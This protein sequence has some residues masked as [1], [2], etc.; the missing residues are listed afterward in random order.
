[1]PFLALPFFE[2]GFDLL[3]LSSISSIFSRSANP[4]CESSLSDFDF[5]HPM[6]SLPLVLSL[7]F[8]ELDD[9]LPGI[10]RI[11]TASI[12]VPSLEGGG[13]RAPSPQKDKRSFFLALRDFFVVL[14]YL[15]PVLGAVISFVALVGVTVILLLFRT[16]SLLLSGLS[17]PKCVCGSFGPAPLPMQPVSSLIIP[18][19]VIVLSYWASEK[20]R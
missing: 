10:L 2:L 3:G 15:S 11:L 12:G 1:L 20:S 7:F 13:I 9:P 6:A 18:S 19:L 17:P 14:C 4:L 5:L 8:L 16:N